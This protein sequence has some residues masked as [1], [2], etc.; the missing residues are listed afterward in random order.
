MSEATQHVEVTMPT[1]GI[2]AYLAMIG[3][4]MTG[5]SF[6]LARDE[7][8]MA[9]TFSACALYLCTDLLL[10]SKKFRFNSHEHIAEEQNH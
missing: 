9:Y 6:A 3:V 5:W 7:T 10:L 4:V 2:L 8:V 1:S